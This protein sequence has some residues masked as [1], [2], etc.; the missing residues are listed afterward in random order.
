MAIQETA[1]LDAGG[2][3]GFLLIIQYC[4]WHA[5]EAFRTKIQKGRYDNENYKHIWDLIWAYVKSMTPEELTKNQKALMVPLRA[6]ERRYLDE[7]WMPKEHAVI[8]VYTSQ[9]PKLGWY[10]TQRN[11][12]MHPI[13]K[14]SLGE[15]KTIPNA[16]AAL[17]L[18]TTKITQKIRIEEDKS[19]TNTPCLIDKE[20]FKVL[21]GR[22]TS[23]FLTLLSVELEETKEWS[24]SSMQI[25][26]HHGHTQKKY[27]SLW[28][29]QVV[30]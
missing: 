20:A 28:Q 25:K 18:K 26:R 6:E 22:V 23:Y 15:Q 5:I 4:E 24:G 27:Q 2:H 7:E 11:E 17:A 30:S 29:L 1:R 10:T 3:P 21:I 8:R 14:D 16:C 19:R 13:I 9:Y 12:G